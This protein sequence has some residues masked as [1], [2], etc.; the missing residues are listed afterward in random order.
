[1]IEQAQRF[2]GWSSG[3]CQTNG[4]EIHYLRS[5][6]GNETPLIALHGLIGS[7]ACLLPFACAL[8]EDFDRILPDAR[9]HG[10]SDAPARGYLYADLARDV[11]RLIHELELN[12]PVLLGHSMGGMTAILAAGQLGQ[13]ISALVLVDPA[14]MSSELQREVF[15]SPVAEDHRRLLKS[16]REELLADAR[17]RS[18]HRSEE[19]IGYLADAR[20]R[21]SPHSFE[22]LT[23]P[24][25]DYRELVQALR[26]PTLLVISE[27]GIVSSETARE[28]QNLN[29]ALSVEM[30]PDAGHGLPYDQPERLAAVVSLFLLSMTSAGRRVHRA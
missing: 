6:G 21:T 26:V 7:G 19:M 9:G 24:N 2:P 18:P 16:P 25:P 15:E 12:A 30:V 13:T 27:R 28:L 20:L 5:G 11:M 22:V 3:I 23:P 17:K 8:G 1:M 4:I 10:Y 29:P 14:F